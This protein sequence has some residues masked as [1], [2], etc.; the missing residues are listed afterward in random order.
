MT[1]KGLGAG[2]MI[3]ALAATLCAREAQFTTRDINLG[4]FAIDDGGKTVAI[5]SPQ[6]LV[7]WVLI[8]PGD[9]GERVERVDALCGPHRERSAIP[10]RSLAPERCG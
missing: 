10:A 4:C 3:G 7:D 5:V 2:F 8:S 1:R 9:K 6:G